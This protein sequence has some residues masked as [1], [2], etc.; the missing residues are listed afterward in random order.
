MKPIKVDVYKKSYP[1][2]VQPEKAEEAF[3]DCHLLIYNLTIQQ[4]NKY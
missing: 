3:Q 2:Y 4:K 1:V